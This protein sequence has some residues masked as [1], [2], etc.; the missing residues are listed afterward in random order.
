M[1]W[2]ESAVLAVVRVALRKRKAAVDAADGA[3]QTRHEA[4][5]AKLDPNWSAK[6][7]DWA[8]AGYPSVK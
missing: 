3:E 5:L 7:T 4:S 6:N 1:A 2:V 8:N